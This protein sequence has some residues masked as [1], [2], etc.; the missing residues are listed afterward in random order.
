MRTENFNVQHEALGGSGM[1][2]RG[3]WQRVPE[4]VNKGELLIK[5]LACLP[6]P[7]ATFSCPCLCHYSQ[8]SQWWLTAAR[9]SKVV[10]RISPSSGLITI[11]VDR[12]SLHTEFSESPLFA[13]GRARDRRIELY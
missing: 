10:R 6:V 9:P 12:T 11:F 8:L 1:L 3:P 7:S 2:S 4:V 13:D 5:V